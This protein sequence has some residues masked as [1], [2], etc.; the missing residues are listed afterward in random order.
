[1]AKEKTLNV[2]KEATTLE[3]VM[4]KL[5]EKYSECQSKE[6]NDTITHLQAVIYSINKI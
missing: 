4:V 6:L 1:M 5:K 2:K 3:T